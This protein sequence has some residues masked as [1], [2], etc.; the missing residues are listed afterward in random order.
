MFRVTIEQ[1]DNSTDPEKKYV[2]EINK[3]KIY[4]QEVEQLDIRE[5]ISLVNKYLGVKKE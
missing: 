2:L 5:L 1:F 3:K 4:E